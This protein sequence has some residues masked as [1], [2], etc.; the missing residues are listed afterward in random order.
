MLSKVRSTETE[1]REF[2]E[3]FAYYDYGEEEVGMVPFYPGYP[4]RTSLV[5]DTKN[6]LEN[7]KGV[8]L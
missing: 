4:D 2:A 5:N 1:M 7:G 3:V 8:G 6:G